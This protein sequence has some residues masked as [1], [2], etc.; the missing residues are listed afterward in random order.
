MLPATGSTATVHTER[1]RVN[2]IGL[3]PCR[4]NSLY[5][6][7]MRQMHITPEAL[8]EIGVHIP[9]THGF[10]GHGDVGTRDGADELGYLCAVGQNFLS[11]DRTAVV[12]LHVEGGGLLVQIHPNK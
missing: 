8:H 2:R 11:K 7:G 3:N 10:H 12:V 1:A 6:H 9:L 5:L 4:G